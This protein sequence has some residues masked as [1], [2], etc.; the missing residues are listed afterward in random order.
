MHLGDD[1]MAIE[2]AKRGVEGITGISNVTY[3]LISV[4][5]NKL[6]AVA[7]IE[8]YKRDAEGDREVMD[9]L[10]RIQQRETDDLGELKRMLGSRLT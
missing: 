8:G 2:Q 6:E 10:D 4:M 3:N 5:H 1:T 7:A 9:L